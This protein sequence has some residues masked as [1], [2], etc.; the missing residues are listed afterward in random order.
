MCIRC[1]IAHTREPAGLCSACAID[2]R[3]EIRRGLSELNDYLA[4][5]A[6]F[7]DWLRGRGG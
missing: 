4:F 7:D 5:W 3:C 2:T 1:R 6:A